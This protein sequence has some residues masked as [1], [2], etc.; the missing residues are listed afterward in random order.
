MTKNFKKI[1]YLVRKSLLI[2]FNILIIYL[3]FFE[4][5]FNSNFKFLF[6]IFIQKP[7]ELFNNIHNKY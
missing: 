5:Y 2:I 3:I 4:N 7:L 6:K 1:N